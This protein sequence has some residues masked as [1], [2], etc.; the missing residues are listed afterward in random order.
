VITPSDVKLTQNQPVHVPSP[1][2]AKPHRF[3]WCQSIER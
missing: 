2:R 3:L 1:S